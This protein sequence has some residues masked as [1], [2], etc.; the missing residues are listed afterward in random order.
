QLF[1][2]GE[3]LLAQ[4]VPALVEPTLVLV[5]PLLGDVMWGVGRAWR[6]VDEEGLIGRERLLLAHP[7]DGLVGQIRHEVVALFGCPLGRGRGR[8]FVER[9]VVLVGLTTNEAEK[10]LEA[11]AG[12]PVV[13]RA[14]RAGLPHRHLVALAEVSG[15]IAIEPLDLSKGC[16]GVRA[17]R[18]VAGRR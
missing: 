9:R 15:G 14:G 11:A 6:E 3:G 1:L 7:G 13:E 4:L 12:G 10:V 5:G 17:N 2:T 18:I 8:P 16:A